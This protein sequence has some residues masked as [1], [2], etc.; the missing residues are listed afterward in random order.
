M[1]PIHCPAFNCFCILTRC[2]RKGNFILQSDLP[3]FSKQCSPHFLPVIQ[4]SIFN[5][6]HILSLYIKVE[7]LFIIDAFTIDMIMETLTPVKSQ[8]EAPCVVELSALELA[9]VCARITG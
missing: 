8:G 7:S 9:K 2:T 3:F 6:I 1:S 5:S 4:L